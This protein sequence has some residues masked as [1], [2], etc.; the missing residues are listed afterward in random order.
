MTISTRAFVVIAFFAVVAL[1]L[2]GH[3]PTVAAQPG[4]PGQPGVVQPQII[5]PAAAQPA[6]PRIQ[7]FQIEQPDRDQTE[8]SGTGMAILF[9][10]FAFGTIGGALFV[11]TRRN[12]IAAVM[13]MVG[14]F[15]AVAGIYM[16]LYANFLAVVQ[17]LVYAGAIMVLFVFVVMILNKPEDEPWALVGIPGKALAGLAMLYLTVRLGQTLWA[18]KP[19][20]T[21]EAVKATMAAPDPVVIT[22]AKGV[23]TGTYEWGSTAG[24][25]TNLFD[26][27]LFPFEAVSI[28]L[29]VAVVGAIAIARPLE[30]DAEEGVGVGVDDPGSE[31]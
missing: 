17:M 18:V 31:A 23:V 25:G 1:A 14:T 6:R 12:L 19:G 29:L 27:Y 10:L 22:N 26:Q 15:F 11:I 30:D 28:L 7:I 21:E 13:G 4:Q 24:V 2:I 20:A 3:A 16:M 8:G 5:D 9:W